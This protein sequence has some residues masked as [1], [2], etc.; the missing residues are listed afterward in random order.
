MTAYGGDGHDASANSP[1]PGL[2]MSL[3][4]FK[5]AGV[6]ADRVVMGLPWYGYDYSCDDNTTGAS[7]YATIGAKQG[8]PQITYQAAAVYLRN[9]TTGLKYNHTTASAFFDYECDPAAPVP[10]GGVKAC[11]GAGRHQVH[12]DTPGTI[13]IKAAA[14]RAAGVRGIAW[15][16]TGSVGECTPS[17]L[18]QCCVCHDWV[19]R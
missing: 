7:C 2:L 6:P 19:D 18:Q 9:S 16:N 11:A 3:E 12:L 14:L 13:A 10:L 15:W 5:K 1:L 4:Q 8:A 17:A